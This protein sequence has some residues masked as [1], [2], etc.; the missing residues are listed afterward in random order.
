MRKI[1]KDYFPN[2]VLLS[3]DGKLGEILIDFHSRVTK[4]QEGIVN[5]CP[6]ERVR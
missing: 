5:I 6:S 4:R 2:S 3:P 1:L